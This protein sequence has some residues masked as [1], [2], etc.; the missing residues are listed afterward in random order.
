MIYQL[1]PEHVIFSTA[2]PTAL[3]HYAGDVEQTFVFYRADDKPYSKDKQYDY[4]E[5]VKQNL[6]RSFSYVY[7]HEFRGPISEESVFRIFN[8]P[9]K[10]FNKIIRT[11][12]AIIQKPYNP[13]FYL[14][15]ITEEDRLI[16]HGELSYYSES[17]LTYISKNVKH[18]DWFCHGSTYLICLP[19]N[20]NFIRNVRKIICLMQPDEEFVKKECPQTKTQVLS[21]MVIKQSV[22]VNDTKSRKILLGNNSYRI[23]EYKKLFPILQ[24]LNAPVTFMIPYGYIQEKVES[25]KKDASR[26]LSNVEYWTDVVSY[27]EYKKRIAAY[28]VY[29]CPAIGQSGLGAINACFFAGVKVYI[30]GNNYEFEKQNGYIVNNIS[31]LQNQTIEEILQYDETDRQ[32]NME[33]VQKLYDETEQSKNWHNYLLEQV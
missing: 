13:Y 16:I 18:Y 2:I 22:M 27:E 7:M 23:D 6:G 33:L 28:K 14:K 20:Q 3:L 5:I 10:V 1:I 9:I 29:M 30:A 11:F 12:L 32:Y 21:Y 17:L 26:A 24:S 8:F 4:V 19:K 31:E 25:F 15:H